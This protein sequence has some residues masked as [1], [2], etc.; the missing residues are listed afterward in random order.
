MPGEPRRAA[1]SDASGCR[2]R[3]KRSTTSCSLCARDAPAPLWVVDWS[4]GEDDDFRA[5]C[6]EAGVEARILRG[7]ALGTTVGTRF[8]R[9]RSWP[10]YF[11]LAAGG[12]WRAPAAPPGCRAP[13]AG[14]GA[15]PL[16]RGP[17]P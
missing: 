15:P 16:P 12:L 4:D 17:R 14:G 2:P 8:H 11:T 7:P 3:S 6:A 9:L 13:R 10:T 1:G 5:A